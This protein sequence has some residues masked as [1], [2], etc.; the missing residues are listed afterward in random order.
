MHSSG[1][2]GL[3]GIAMAL[4]GF[5]TRG[6]VATPIVPSRRIRDIFGACK[7]GDHPHPWL[8]ARI[9]HHVA[10]FSL[11]SHLVVGSMLTCGSQIQLD[12]IVLP[13]LLSRTK[14]PW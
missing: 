4:H 9:R 8:L 12:R 5:S 2:K 14:A 1:N 7:C 10:G 6:S 3:F 11:R 13:P